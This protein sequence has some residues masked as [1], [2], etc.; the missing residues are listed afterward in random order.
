MTSRASW[1]AR[2]MELASC[3]FSERPCLHKSCREQLK[4]TPN[5]NVGPPHIYAHMCA[6]HIDTQTKPN[7]DVCTTLL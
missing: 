6:S 3:G 7:I 1:L 5:V 4:R 2:L